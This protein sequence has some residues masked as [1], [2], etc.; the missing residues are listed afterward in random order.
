MEEL[1]YQR[2]EEI[3]P[4]GTLIKSVAFKPLKSVAIILIVGIAILFVPNLWIRI[5]GFFFIAIAL[6]V[7][8]YVKDKK[9][10]DIYEKGCI[11]FNP[12]NS[13]LA[14]Y[15][16]FENVEEWDIHHESGHDTVEF[17]LLD[18]NRAIVDTFQTNKIFD[19]LEKAIPDKNHIRIMAKKNKEMNISPVSAL[20]NLVN[21]SKNKKHSD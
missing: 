21:N 1:K 13:E 6:F 10:I 3:K 9:T 11:V 20:K 2:L 15:L 18:K 8:M 4:E 14:Y 19:A 16:D 12:T 17:T 5:L 7:F